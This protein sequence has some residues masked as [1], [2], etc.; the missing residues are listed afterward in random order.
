METKW[1][2]GVEKVWGK[3]DKCVAKSVEEPWK[4]GWK[5][6]EKVWEKCEARVEKVR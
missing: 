3:F 1:G 6:V 4:K 2:K 5:C